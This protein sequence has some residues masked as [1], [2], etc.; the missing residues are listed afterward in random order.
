M[1]EHQ[2]EEE[3]EQEIEQPEEKKVEITGQEAVAM[4]KF[5]IAKA[6]EWASTLG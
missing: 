4:V 1:A 5:H 2:Q 6:M 3:Q